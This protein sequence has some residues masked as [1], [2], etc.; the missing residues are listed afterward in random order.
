MTS[1][2]LVKDLCLTKKFRTFPAVSFL[3]NPSS[4]LASPYR[5]LSMKSTNTKVRSLVRAFQI[6]NILYIQNAL[7]KFPHNESSVLEMKNSTVRASE[8]FLSL[9]QP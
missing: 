1:P 3:L 5:M 9:A 4:W 2:C 7:T 8:L 6:Q